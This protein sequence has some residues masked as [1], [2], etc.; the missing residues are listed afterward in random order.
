MKLWIDNMA[1]VVA[2]YTKKGQ[3]QKALVIADSKKHCN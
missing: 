1:D 3:M 2:K